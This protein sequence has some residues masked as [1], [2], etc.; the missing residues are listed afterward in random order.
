MVPSLSTSL[1]VVHHLL[2]YHISSLYQLVQHHLRFVTATGLYPTQ[3]IECDT[4]NTGGVIVI[5][6]GDH[7]TVGLKVSAQ[8]KHLPACIYRL[9]QPVA[10]DLILPHLQSE[11][12][13]ST[14]IVYATTA[15][16]MRTPIIL[17]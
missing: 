7:G 9:N 4:A 6:D 11:F 8:M 17:Q 1:V 15:S 2:R 3:T 5:D 10:R 13:L 14:D 12:A 16:Y